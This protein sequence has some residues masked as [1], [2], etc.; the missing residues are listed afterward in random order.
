[1]KLLDKKSI[2]PSQLVLAGDQALIVFGLLSAMFAYYRLLSIHVFP[3]HTIFYRTTLHLS[4]AVSAWV[5]FGV[6]RKVIRFFSSK[7]YLNII[8]ILLLVHFFS[9]ISN[10]FFPLKHHLKPEIFIISFFISSIYIIG[11]RFIISYL[12]YYYSRSK[13]SA[14]Q[15]KLMIYGAGEMGV[16]LKKSIL[17]NYQDEYRLVAFLDDDRK[18][19]GRY[20]G[21]VKVLDA[22]K[23]LKK[24]IQK[25][26]ITDIIIANKGITSERKS[27]FLEDTLSFNVRIKELTSIQSLFNSNFNLE[28]LASIDI[29]DLLNRKPIQLFNEHV[30]E[31]L[32]DKVVMVT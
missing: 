26:G 15:K 4:L 12:Y 19:I 20:I 17:T 21:G 3:L 29:N 13:K 8:F 24:E 25:N 11:T 31:S 14:N 22:Q 18:K 9:G 6:Y 16:F 1:M 2:R 10:A 7:D 23:E 30:A 5:L 27:K 32:I 28:K